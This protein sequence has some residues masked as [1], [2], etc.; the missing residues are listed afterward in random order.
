MELQFFFLF[1]SINILVN[2]FEV[3]KMSLSKLIASNR[4]SDLCLKAD[5]AARLGCVQPRKN[6]AKRLLNRNGDALNTLF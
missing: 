5:L 3:F 2:V 4:I 1:F 6:A